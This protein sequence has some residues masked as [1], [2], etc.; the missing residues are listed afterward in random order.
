M[1]DPRYPTE[2]QDADR[3]GV[4]DRAEGRVDA[5]RDG[6][7]DRVEHRH[8]ADRPA[9]RE[10]RVVRPG[11]DWAGMAVRVLLT[12]LGAAGLIVSA[13]MDWIDG[14]TAVNLDIRALWEATFDQESATFIA[15]VGFVMI[16]LGLLAIVG[17]APRSGWLTGLAGA[18]AIAAFVLFAIQ[19]YRADRTV[20]DIDPGAWV[21]LAGGALALIG[22]FFGSRRVVVAGEPPVVEVP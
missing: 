20:Q 3:D 6:V 16:V 5:D 1:I 9:V 4:D 8:Y 10:E 14:T 17:M 22:G 13:F 21:A 18:L 11:F 19:V 2:R 15:T 7:D 12:L